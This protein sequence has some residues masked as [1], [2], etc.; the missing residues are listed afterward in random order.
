MTLELWFLL[1][2][3]SFV[4]AIIPGPS[5]LLALNHGIVYG[6]KKSMQIVKQDNRGFCCRF[7]CWYSCV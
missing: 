1:F 4:A 2:T 6:K 7:W 3:T 5:M